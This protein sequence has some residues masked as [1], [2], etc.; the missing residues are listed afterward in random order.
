MSSSS[1]RPFSILVRISL[2]KGSPSR[3]GVHQPQDSRA[4]KVIR[5]RVASTR[6][7]LSSKTITPPEPSREPA[8]A[9]VS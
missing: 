2:T 5:F 7:W 6:Q 3:H 9:T 8:L 1:P 4:K